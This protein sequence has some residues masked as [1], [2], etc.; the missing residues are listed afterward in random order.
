MKAIKITQEILKKINP[1]DILYAEL[2]LDG[3]MGACGTARIFTL[4][5]GVLKFHLIDGIRQ[6]EENAKIYTEVD[7]YLK[8]LKEAGVLQFEYAGYGN[9]AY[10]APLVKFSH[11]DDHSSFIYKDAKK[12]YKIPVSCAGVYDHL[13]AKFAEREVPIEELEEYFNQ[14]HL[15]LTTDEEYFYEQYYNQIK[16]TDAGMG[17]MDMTAFDYYNAVRFLRHISSED[18]ILNDQEIMEVA[19]AH[20]KYRLKYVSEKLGWTELDK[21]FVQM[22][23]QKTTDLSKRVKKVL[24]EGIEEIYA[25]LE[26]IKSDYGERGVIKLGNLENLF[27]QPVLVDFSKSAHAKIIKT[28]MEKSGNSFNPDG[29]AVALYFA[30]YLLNED[31]LPFSDVLP[32]VAHVVETMPNDDFNNTHTD[33]LFW[34]C[35]EILDHAWRYLEENEKTQKKYRDM[36][37]ELYWP[38]VGSLWPVLHKNE[39]EFKHESASKIFDD[40]LSFV[41]SLEDITERNAEI[42]TFLDANAEQI[43]YNAGPLGRRAFEYTLRGL[44]SKQELERILETIEPKDYDTY[45]TYPS[46]KEDAKRLLEELFRTDPGA[47]ITGHARLATFEAVLMTPNTIGVGELILGHIDEHFEEFMKIISAEVI[48]LGAE[49]L[50][51]LTGYFIAISKGITEENEFLALKSI[52]EKLLKLGCNA[53][54]LNNAEKYARRHRRTILFQRSALQKLF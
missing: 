28:I 2:A 13:V 23:K 41:M 3:A 50:S 54:E 12:T 18:Y 15:K 30:N 46:S 4:E 52:K 10:K 47:R 51:V 1:K 33:E 9:D 45:L 53:E 16:R 43:G 40:S 21:I 39:Y 49:P 24:G 36:L 25:T 17:W 26:T 32:A 22:V 44:N 20:S 5:K 8:E 19:K 29:K 7:A 11:D 42:K 37:Y 38:R 27:N 35:G 34:L 14:N 6:S 31:K 48:N